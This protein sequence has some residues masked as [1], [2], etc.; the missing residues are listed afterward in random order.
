MHID[1]NHLEIRVKRLERQNRRLGWA[2][3]LLIVLAVASAAR[4]Q[5]PEDTVTR[6]Q[7]FELH[8]DVGHLRADLSI[9]NG[10]PTLRFLDSDGVVRSAFSGDQLSLFEKEGDI[11]ATFTKDGLE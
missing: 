2:C 10:T 5:R 4:S 8:D 6:T 1:F 7:K 9:R 11:L 3:F